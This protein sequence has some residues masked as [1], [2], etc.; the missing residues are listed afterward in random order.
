MNQIN[1]LSVSGDRVILPQIVTIGVYGF[2][3]D[4]FFNALQKAGV[5]IFCDI[6]RRRSVRGAKYAFANSKRL[7]ARLAGLGI[8]YEHLLDLAPTAEIRDLQKAVD[9]KDAVAKRKRVGL[10]DSFI[11]TYEMEILTPF[12]AETFLSELGQDSKVIALFC[13]ERE[14][15]ACHR[16]LVADKLARELGL[17]VNHLVP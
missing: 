3:E 2:S 14:P 15:A 13:V 4:S 6:R 16:S 11:E 17:E 10:D 1:D 12:N 8:R 7:Q 5:D 9:E